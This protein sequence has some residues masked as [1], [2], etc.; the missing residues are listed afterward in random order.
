MSA[1][2]LEAGGNGPGKSSRTVLSKRDRDWTQ[3]AGVILALA[4][5]IDRRTPPGQDAEMTCHMGAKTAIIEAPAIAAWQPR[6]WEERFRR[7]FRRR[8]LVRGGP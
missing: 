5:E 3:Q 2:L 7:A 4:E 1:I 8:L 6:V